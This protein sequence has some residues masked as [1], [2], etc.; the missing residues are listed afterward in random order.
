LVKEEVMKRIKVIIMIVVVTVFTLEGL[1]YAKPGKQ[2]KKEIDKKWKDDNEM[3]L[4][5]ERMERGEELNVE[6][7][8]KLEEMIREIKEMEDRVY[9]LKRS[10]KRKKKEEIEK[11]LSKEEEEERKVNEELSKMLLED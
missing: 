9:K 1:I 2:E 6:D 10:K 11:L 4:L 5:E 7:K 8:K 3:K